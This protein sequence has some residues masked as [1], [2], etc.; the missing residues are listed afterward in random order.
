[1]RSILISLPLLV[2]SMI[3]PVAGHTE[4]IPVWPDTAIVRLQAQALLQDL[5]AR[6]LSHDSAT[7]TLD[8]WCERHDL[9]RGEKVVAERMRDIDKPASEDVRA[10]LKVSDGERVNYRRVRLKCGAHVLSEADNWYVPGRLTADM[11]TALDTTD[12]AFGRVVQPLHF[13]RHT[14]SAELLWWPM[15][16]AWE[17]GA[18]VETGPD[19][20]HIPE[21]V[22][23]HRA[24]LS[25]PDATPIS[26]VVETYTRQVLAFPLPKIA[27]QKPRQ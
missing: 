15:P 7:L 27:D 26:L 4:E 20:L 3:L 12:A 23:Q 5:N 8:H 13:Q 17:M 9:A 10:A 14:I 11:N 16:E 6:L 1:M 2:S 19:P 18:P 21:E 22:L 25:L 24:L